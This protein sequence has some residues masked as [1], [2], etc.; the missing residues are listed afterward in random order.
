MSTTETMAKN[1]PRPRRS[2]N[3]EFK[4]E[5]PH[6]DEGDMRDAQSHG[7]APDHAEDADRD[8]LNE[9]EPDDPLCRRSQTDSGRAR[10]RGNQLAPLLTVPGK[11]PTVAHCVGAASAGGGSGW[12]D[13][14]GPA[15]EGRTCPNHPIVVSLP[16]GEDRERAV[17]WIPQA[18]VDP[19]VIQSVS[20]PSEHPW[21][22]RR[23]VIP[24]PR[25]SP[26]LEIP[27]PSAATTDESG[28]RRGDATAFRRDR[29][30]LTSQPRPGP[31]AD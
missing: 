11:R 3:D 20:P 13:G 15:G 23:C 12:R 8:G 6:C 27:W 30:P 2:F 25:R 1:D 4:A 17:A 22:G 29:A 26:P 24:P 31:P 21:L 19:V 14:F 28:A 18:H 5:G 16:S 7:E 10:P 9:R